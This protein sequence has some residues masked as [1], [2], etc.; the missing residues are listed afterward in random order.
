MQETKVIQLTKSRSSR[1]R[2]YLVNDGQGM[3]CYG[4]P[5][6]HYSHS[7]LVR[8]ANVNNRGASAYLSVDGALSCEWMPVEAKALIRKTLGL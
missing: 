7:W 5:S 8:S 6:E 4:M 1:D 2:F 3:G